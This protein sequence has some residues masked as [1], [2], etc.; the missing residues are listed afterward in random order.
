MNIH[1]FEKAKQE[2]ARQDS[3]LHGNQHYSTHDSFVEDEAFHIKNK[4]EKR[5]HKQKQMK[6]IIGGVGA[7]MLFLIGVA[8]YSQ[9][10][11]YTLS[12]DETY[13]RGEGVDTVGGANTPRTGEDIIR[14]L[15]KHILVPEG[16]PQIAEVQ[17][18]EKLKETQA[19]FKDVKNGDVVI[20][21]PDIIFVYRPS[22][23]I[24]IASTDISGVGQTKP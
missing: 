24:V 18:S 19:F 13:V 8:G 4:I 5:K 1:T 15:K 7:F 17:D 23:D 12:K 14:A 16:S 21:Y 9:Y 22:A 11:L 6:F 20:I 10:K 3:L 2:Y